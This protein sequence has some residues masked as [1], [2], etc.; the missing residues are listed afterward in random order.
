MT[1]SSEVARWI[2]EKAIT[3]K[4][5]ADLAAFVE[6]EMGNVLSA[7]I[8]KVSQVHR[9]ETTAALAA[10]AQVENE[11]SDVKRERDDLKANASATMQLFVRP[12]GND[13]NSG[14]TQDEAFE[15]VP[16]ALAKAQQLGGATIHVAPPTK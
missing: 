6:V 7:E 13:A 16:A 9:A 2:A 14:L 4:D 3:T 12:D 15:T 11:L 5:E 8:E 1:V 10:K